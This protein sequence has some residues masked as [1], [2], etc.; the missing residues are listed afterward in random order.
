M[1][2]VFLSFAAFAIIAATDAPPVVPK[3]V[4]IYGVKKPGSTAMASCSDIDT[5]DQTAVDWWIR[6][7]FSGQNVAGSRAVGSK[8]G[9]NAVIAIVRK[10][11][12]DNPS[13]PLAWVVKTAY[14]K[15]EQR[16]M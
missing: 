2:V 14:E 11:C 10:A 8:I 1:R 9:D 15:V 3:I 12:H 7:Y 6:G 5:L 13:A 4:T 16:Q